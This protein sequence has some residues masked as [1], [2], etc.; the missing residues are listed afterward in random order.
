MPL[1]RVVPEGVYGI[2]LQGPRDTARTKLFESQFPVMPYHI[3]R[4]QR[5]EKAGPLAYGGVA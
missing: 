3:S 2:D 5:L 4:S 1:K